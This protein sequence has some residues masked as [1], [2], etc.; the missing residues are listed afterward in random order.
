MLMLHNIYIPEEI[1]LEFSCQF[2]LVRKQQPVKNQNV[3]VER[4]N[5]NESP[6]SK[7]ISKSV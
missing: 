7:N 6:I 5:F 4:V 2:I 1:C 3:S